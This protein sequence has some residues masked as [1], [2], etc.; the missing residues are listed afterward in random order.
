MACS[1]CPTCP[2]SV[3]TI[4]LPSAG[5]CWNTTVNFVNSCVGLC[6][7]ANEYEVDKNSA[8]AKGISTG[9]KVAY[10]GFD[11]TVGCNIS[12]SY[13]INQSC[14]S[15]AGI[16]STYTSFCPS[17]NLFTV[18]FIK[19]TDGKIYKFIP[20][21]S[22]AKLSTIKSVVLY[23]APNGWLGPCILVNLNQNT[24]Q[25]CCQQI[26]NLYYQIL[27]GRAPSVVIESTSG[28]AANVILRIC[29]DLTCPLPPDSTGNVTYE[30][31]LV[32]LDYG[33]GAAIP[34]GNVQVGPTA[35]DGGLTPKIFFL[36]VPPNINVS[37]GETYCVNLTIE[38][39]TATTNSGPIP[40]TTGN[41]TVE[42]FAT[43]D[44]IGNSCCI[45]SVSQTDNTTGC[46]TPYTAPIIVGTG[47][48]S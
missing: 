11:Y 4:T 13:T 40:V 35:G 37:N 48:A 44:I 24:N 9:S 28:P 23:K 42:T 27:P 46:Q 33:L 32:C 20:V 1:S 38:G 31:D 45:L 15:Q 5:K 39:N 8:K 3:S 14:D 34:S 10:L 17:K 43:L 22:N 36:E 16:P 30:L 6:D 12:D 2:S 25:A 26:W 21:N 19:A 7:I 41:A 47:A 18:P 29:P